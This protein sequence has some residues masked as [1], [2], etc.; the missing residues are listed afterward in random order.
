MGEI[1]KIRGLEVTYQTPEG[2]VK[3]VDGVDLELREGEAMGLVGESGCGKSTLGKSLLG[4]LPPD[5]EL[6]GEIL[7]NGNPLMRLTDVSRIPHPASRIT[8]EEFRK[9]RGEKVGLIFQDPMTRL[10]PLMRIEDHFIELLRSH[11]KG[12]KKDEAREAGKLELEKIGIPSRRAKHY[13]HEFS[14]GMRQRIMIA[15]TTVLKPKLL[16]ADEP[17]TSLDVIVEAQIIEILKE[18]KSM[19]M[20]LLLITHNLALVAESCDRVSVMYGGKIVET[21]PAR[22]L[23]ENPLHPYTQ[24]LLQSTIHLGTTSLKSIDG[25]PPDLLNPPTGCRFHPRCTFRKEICDKEDPQT[26]QPTGG[27]EVK[28]VLYK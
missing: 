9:L 25:S 18:L 15:L 10:N 19:G 2:G 27:R 22:E 13:P 4:I 7:L 16:V 5:T 8:R 11:S 6:R 24:G 17:T 20:T 23:F 14:G 21:A 12:M 3:A 26:W 1:L 28:C